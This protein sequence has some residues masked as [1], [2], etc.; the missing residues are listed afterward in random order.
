MAIAPDD[1]QRP[2]LATG[3]A[4]LARGLHLEYLTLAWNVVGVAAVAVAAIA[5]RSVALAGF[6]LDSLVEIF[7]SVVVV[8]QLRGVNQ[9]RERLALR[10]IGTAF[11]VLALYILAQAAYTLLARIHPGRSPLGV[12]WL[13]A[14]LV[15]MLLLSWGK[16]VTGR[17]LGTRCC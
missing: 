12:A 6:G 1:V 16:L 9:G 7:A 13:A 10:L 5:A 14:T 3:A 17:Q 8:W 2:D 15:A 4:L 11:F